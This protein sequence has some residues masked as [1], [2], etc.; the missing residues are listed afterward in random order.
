MPVMFTDPFNVYSYVATSASGFTG[1]IEVDD[2]ITTGALSPQAT[3]AITMGET[4]S[5]Q[6]DGTYLQVTR[7][8]FPGDS[9]QAMT[10]QHLSLL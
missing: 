2:T 3:Q 7:T 5:P 6:F 1:T 8:L 10:V 4:F 9:L